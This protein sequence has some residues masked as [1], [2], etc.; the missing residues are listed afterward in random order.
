MKIFLVPIRK[1]I[2]GV[3]LRKTIFTGLSLQQAERPV[4]KTITNQNLEINDLGAPSSSWVIYNTTPTPE[5]QGMS[6]KK[7]QKVCRRWRNRMTPVRLHL[8]A[9][10]EKLHP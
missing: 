6:R 4:Q 7:G 3:S 9:L 2:R 1:P 5:A 10:P 8:L